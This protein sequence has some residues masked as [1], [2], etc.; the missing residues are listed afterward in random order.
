MCLQLP[1][2]STQQDI[3]RTSE[4]HRKQTQNSEE[5]TQN[6]EIKARTKNFSRAP[7]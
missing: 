4:K 3:V 2:I 1:N 6:S 5:K 7:N